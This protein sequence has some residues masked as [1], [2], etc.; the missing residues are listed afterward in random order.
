MIINLKTK[1]KIPD[2]LIL[3]IEGAGG[4]SILHCQNKKQ[5]LIARP[6]KA[7]SERVPQF[8]RIR[9]SIL[10]N[11]VHITSFTDVQIFIGE[12]RFIISRRKYNDVFGAL[13]DHI[14]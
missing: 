14:K 4:Y 5:I 1:K 9:G 3:Y 10:V 11:P 6:L 8:V 2:E 13:I 12:K 7:L